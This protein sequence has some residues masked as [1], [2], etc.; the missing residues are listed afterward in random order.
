MHV[1]AERD[2]VFGFRPNFKEHLGPDLG[3]S[4][5]SHTQDEMQHSEA[6]RTYQ[7][8]LV[9]FFSFILIISLS[10]I[11]FFGRNL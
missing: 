4:D 6:D 5:A 7:P 9:V 11:R 3:T 8:G 10:D 2:S 1:D